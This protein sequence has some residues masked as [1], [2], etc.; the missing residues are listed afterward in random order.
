[1]LKSG[2][3]AFTARNAMTQI[4]EKTIDVQYFVWEP[5]SIGAVLVNGTGR[6]V[7]REFTHT[8]YIVVAR[9]TVISDVK[10]T[11]G[12]SAK[13]SRGMASTAILSGRHVGIER[14]AKRHTARRTRPIS[15]MT[16]ETTIACNTSMIDVKCRAEGLSIMA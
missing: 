9:I 2:E 10:M 15:N 7:V 14:G 1:M 16:G 12:A 3:R 11:I 13:G 5:D 8:D 6:Y 4:A